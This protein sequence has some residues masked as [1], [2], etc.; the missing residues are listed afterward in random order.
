MFFETDLA[1]AQ[2]VEAYA[3][4]TRAGVDILWFKNFKTG[5]AERTPFLFFSRNRASL[6]YKS[7]P[8]AWGSTNALSYNFKNGLGLVAVAAFLP[9]GLTAKTGLQFFRQKGAFMFFGWAVADWKKQG[10]IDVFG[11]FRYQPQLNTLLQGFAQYEFF[12][13]YKPSAGFWNITQR[14]RLGI[15]YHTWA[16]GGMAD[17]SQTG[18]NKLLSSYNLGVFLRNEF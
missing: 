10:N 16:L 4:H 6:D 13:V 11:L 1:S 17:V 9:D 14:L 15:K 7:S 2:A 3:G 5:A 12:P 18:K 8:T